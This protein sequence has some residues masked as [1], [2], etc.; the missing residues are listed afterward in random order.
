MSWCELELP[1]TAAVREPNPNHWSTRADPVAEK[2][3]E[4]QCFSETSSL[5]QVSYQGIIKYNRK[6]SFN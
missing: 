3:K 1:G 2:Y 6:H 4:K 5:K